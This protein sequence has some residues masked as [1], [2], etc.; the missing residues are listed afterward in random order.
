MKTNEC[1]FVD[2]FPAWQKLVMRLLMIGFPAVALYAM[3]RH[4][5]LW[6]WIYLAFVVLGQLFLALPAL[7]AHCP[8][9]YKHND[10][11]LLPADMV[12]SL[13]TYRGPRLSKGEKA[14]LT[15]ALAGTVIMPQYWLFR[16][17]VLLILFWALLL[18][19]L[20][21]FQFYLCKRCR[22]T[23]CPANRIPGKGLP[24]ADVTQN[25]C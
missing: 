4:D 16:E 23:G 12:R 6:A 25:E 14:A 11:L 19:F 2:R 13:L 15:I 17:P 21:F 10:C 22:H 18:P 24:Q 9:P 20:G 5:A 8:Y 7:C 1:K 3:F